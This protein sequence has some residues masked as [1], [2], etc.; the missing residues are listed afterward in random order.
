MTGPMPEILFYHLEGAPL[1]RVLPSLLEKT[2]ERGW[3]AVVQAGS[4][5]QAEA[6]D[7][8]LWTYRDEGFLPHAIAGAGSEAD[9]PILI[10]DD[11]NNPN[12][13]NVRFLVDGCAPGFVSSLGRYDR[14]VYLF[15]GHDGEATQQARSF[16]KLVKDAGVDATY[17]QQSGSGKWEKRA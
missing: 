8:H 6:L 10:T 7:T 2:L 9:Q 12:E 13:A 1:D 17:W 16:W 15:D 14:V 4:R 5:E 3:K 11:E